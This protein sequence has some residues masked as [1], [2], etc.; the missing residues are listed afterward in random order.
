LHT[1]RKLLRYVITAALAVGFVLPG[2]GQTVK[3]VADTNV[4]SARAKVRISNFGRI[5]DTYYRGAQPEGHDYNDLAA[6]GVKTVINLTSDDQQAGEQAMV[7]HA[8]MAYVQIPMKGHQPP[9]QAQIKQFLSLTNDAA[10]QPV[11]VHC[12]GGKHRTGVM[13]AVY[14]MT[15]DRWNADQ[16]FREM[17][18]Y[19]FGMDFLHSEFKKFVYQYQS[20]QEATTADAPAST[21]SNVSTGSA[22]LQHPPRS[23]R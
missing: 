4:T 20:S 12:V 16:A 19:K 9:T 14:R 23:Q 13:T 6:L 17:K 22:G 10:S 7:E 3:T 8:G 18:Q 15:Q 1:N 11:F 21:E 2:F 5:N